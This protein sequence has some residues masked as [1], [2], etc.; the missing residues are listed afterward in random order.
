MSHIQIHA[1]VFHGSVIHDEKNFI[2]SFANPSNSVFCVEVF[3][4]NLKVSPDPAQLPEISDNVFQTLLNAVCDITCMNDNFLGFKHLAY[5]KNLF[6]HVD[7][8]LSD[9]AQL[10]PQMLYRRILERS[11]NR[12]VHV[13][14]FL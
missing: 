1:Q 12:I 4:H 3:Q 6:H 10:Y 7:V 11:V 13:V 9:F 2:R 8:F 14:Q 5:V